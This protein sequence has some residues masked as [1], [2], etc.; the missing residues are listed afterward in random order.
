VGG[1]PAG[2]WA[3]RPPFFFLALLRQTK[4][5]LHASS[6]LTPKFAYGYLV[7]NGYVNEDR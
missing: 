6:L 7:P 5:E 3:V 2:G 1:L 4:A